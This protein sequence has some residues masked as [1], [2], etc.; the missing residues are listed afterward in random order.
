MKYKKLYEFIYEEV[1]NNIEINPIWLK[2]LDEN[3]TK[4][5]GGNK[6]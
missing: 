6:E 2:T 3:L 4:L 1:M 5:K